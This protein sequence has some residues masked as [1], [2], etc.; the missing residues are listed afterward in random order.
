LTRARLS[1]LRY[2]KDVVEDVTE[3]VALH[4]R[5]HGYSAGEW[6]DAAVRRYVR[7]A[8][9]LLPRL[10]ALT[11]SD[12]TTRNA[13]KARALAASYD[14]LERR[15]AELAEAEE[16]QAM[17]P[18]LDGNEIMTALG[19]PPGPVVGKAWKYLLELRIER[20]PMSHDEALDA[21]RAWA[22]EQ[23]LVPD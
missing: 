16:L 13:G 8:G 15:I 12:C 4:L 10:H 23:G 22:R 14:A 3:L 11:R 20:G 6:T 9:H 7:D 18:E 21:L 17:R 19:V 2:P 5:F 1:A